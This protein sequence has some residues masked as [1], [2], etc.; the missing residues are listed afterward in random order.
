MLH[1]TGKTLLQKGDYDNAVVMFDRAKQQDPNNVELMR[2]LTYA[3]YLKRDFA[4]AIEAGKELVEN[5][6]AD[7]QCFQMLGLAYKAIASYKECA[8]LYRTGLRKFPNSGVLHNEYGEL[9]AM[10]GNELD[11]AIVEWER[12]IE[13]DPSYSSNYYNAALYYGTKKNWIRSALYGEIFLN[14]E[15]YT[16]RTQDVK[17]QLLASWR[18]LLVPTTLKQ[19]HDDRATSTFEKY[20]TDVLAKVNTNGSGSINDLTEVRTRFIEQWMKENAK[21]YPFGLFNQQQYLLKQNLFGAYN[22]WLFSTGKEAYESWQTAHAKEAAD[23]TAF[24]QSR[25]F[26]LPAGEYYFSK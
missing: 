13:V 14:L 2:D 18:N 21:T 7:E 15:S 5:P 20:V 12:G 25:V 3:N 26:K 19:V 23:F 24:Q 16:R 11:Q 17:N 6:K 8:K 10:D 22:N 4:K 1:Q 9:F